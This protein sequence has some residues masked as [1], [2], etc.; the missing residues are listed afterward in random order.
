MNAKKEFLQEIEGKE[1]LCTYIRTDTYGNED[2]RYNLRLNYTPKEYDEFLES[3]DFNYDDGYGGQ[4]LFGV[5]W[6]VDGTWSDR[7]EYDG[8]EW[9]EHNTCPVI[10]EQL[11]KSIE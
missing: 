9:W 7:G 11:N 3:I 6:Y 5:I 1:V 10:P 4:E 8:S 2:K